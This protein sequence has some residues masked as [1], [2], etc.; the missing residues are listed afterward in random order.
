MTRVD[1][2]ALIAEV[3]DPGS[4][5]SWDEPVYRRDVSEGYREEL[6]R[7]AQS[8]GVDE[9]VL[10][11]GGTVDGHP[12]AVMVGEFGFLGGS[13]G[14]S[15]ADRI[16]A[17]VRRATREGLPLLAAPVSGG[18]RMQEG[19]RAF[20]QMI[21][22]SATILAHRQAG[23]PYLVYLRHPTTGGVYASWGSMGHVTV[24]EPGALIGFLGPRVYEALHGEPFPPGVQ[25]AENLQ[26]HG[27]IDAVL[28]HTR[29]R[30][31]I[32]DVL[33]IAGSRSGEPVAVRP[34]SGATTADDW[35]L[36]ERSRLST[37]PGL[38]SVLRHGADLV[39]PLNGSGRGEWDPALQLAL[40]RFGGYGAV[41]LG[42]DRRAVEEAAALGPGALRTAARGIQLAR[43]LR[44]P[45]VTVI[46]TPGAALS[47]EAEN[48]GLAGEIGRTM[49]ALLDADV[50]VVS[51]IL[52]Q[53]TGGAALALL[54]ADI[55]LAAEN[56]WLAPLP[57]EGA[58]AIVSRTPVNAPDT[59]RRQRIGSW[60]LH[61]DGIADEVIPERGDAFPADVGAAIARALAEL[62]GADLDDAGRA[63]RRHRRGMR[64]LDLATRLTTP[65]G[66]RL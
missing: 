16:C 61:D 53:G 29:L 30:R 47:P 19:T 64:Y 4:F 38:R 5:R 20:V 37:R 62:D 40:A 13:I 24:G 18:T 46:D 15:A 57:P 34:V 55:V 51:V 14:T 52:G 10:T 23:L 32:I 44:L 25:L 42:Q 6:E 58:S 43:E 7:A 36:V 59:A 11:G 56:G 60:R 27:L 63:A 39:V 22:I 66:T 31:F 49:T 3:L 65:K 28:D 1:A 26:R 48:G 8:S 41:V 21:P 54:P 12:V 9:A 33:V 50:P 45:I 2:R 17:A 35:L